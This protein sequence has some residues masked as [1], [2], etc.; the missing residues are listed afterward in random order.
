MYGSGEE[1]FR[2]YILFPFQPVGLLIQNTRLINT[3]N[4]SITRSSAE[5]EPGVPLDSGVTTELF[6]VN[7]CGAVRLEYCVYE[8]YICWSLRTEYR[9][10]PDSP[11][12]RW[13]SGLGFPYP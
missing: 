1:L 3:R 10:S 2:K 13:E 9:V 7:L 5:L 11:V 12:L 6:L 8:N 4:I